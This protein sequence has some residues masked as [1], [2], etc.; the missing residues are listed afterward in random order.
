MGMTMTKF[1][2]VTLDDVTSEK[3]A[4]IEN[5]EDYN[6]PTSSEVVAF[7]SKMVKEEGF[8]I[9]LSEKAIC[10]KYGNL[11]KS[12][13]LTIPDVEIRRFPEVEKLF[14]EKDCYLGDR[15]NRGERIQLANLL[16]KAGLTRPSPK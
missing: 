7:I 11:T 12:L 1:G 8:Y 16:E 4:F 3:G 10:N 6:G 14:V 5:N 9:H 15:L 2:P 13:V